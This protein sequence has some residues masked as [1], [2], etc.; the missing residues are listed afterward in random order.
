MWGMDAWASQSHTT[1]HEVHLPRQRMAKAT[2]L[3]AEAVEANFRQDGQLVS[4]F[5]SNEAAHELWMVWKRFRMEKEDTFSSHED[6]IRHF[7]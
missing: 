7:G 6:I 2:R 5:M 4:S 1:V 3:V